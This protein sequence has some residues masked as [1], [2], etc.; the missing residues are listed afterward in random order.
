MPLSGSPRSQVRQE[1]H[2]FKRGTL[3]SGSKRGPKVRS[4]RQAIA[5]SLSEAGLA[6]KSKRGKR[7]MR[8][9]RR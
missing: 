9:G 7:T 6:R 1:M 8:R 5:I 4:R 3:H 2:K